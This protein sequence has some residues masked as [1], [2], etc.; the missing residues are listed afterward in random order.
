M[1]QVDLHQHI[2][3]RPLLDALA[4]RRAVPFVRRTGGLTVLHCAGE[5]TCVIAT[6]AEAPARRAA[7]ARADGVDV[8][9]VALSSPIGV[10]ALPREQ[11]LE[12]IA[13]HMTGVAALPDELAAWGPV[14][15]DGADPDDVDQRVAEGCV[16]ISLPAGALSG[17]RRLETLARVLERIARHGVPLLVHPGPGRGDRPADV[18]FAEPLWWPAMTPY[19]APADLL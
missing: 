14:A 3:T 1:R 17:P 9:V 18:S 10:E 13:A 12:L 2:W 19:V 15:L 6:D 7:L 4:R 8:A 5:P 11:S 16:G